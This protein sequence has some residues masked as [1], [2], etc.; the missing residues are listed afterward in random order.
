MLPT[1]PA[2]PGR[3]SEFLAGVRAQVPLLLG[4]APFGAAYGAYAV[5][6]GLSAGLAQAMSVIVFGGASQLVAARLIAGAVPAAIVVLAVALV[7][8]RHVLYSASVAPH[9]EH[10]PVRWRW[11]LA[12]LLTDECYAMAM[13]RYRAGDAAPY[14]HWF[15]LGTG[16]MLWAAWQLTTAMGVVLG[17]AVPEGWALD[18]ALPLTFLAL[19]VPTLRTRAATGAAAVAGVIAVVGYRWPYGTGLISAA[20]AGMA[21]GLLLDGGGGEG[22]GASGASGG[23]GGSR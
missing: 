22:G 15:F 19:L 17:A 21:G 4:V 10:L 8:L 2:Y 14:R 1:L 3:R 18:F 9:V 7:N 13:A 5:E 11:L 20:L 6:S 12:Y 16:L 23:S